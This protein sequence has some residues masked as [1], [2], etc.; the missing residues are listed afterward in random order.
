[1]QAS[2]SGANGLLSEVNGRIFF[3]TYVSEID[4]FPLLHLTLQKSNI[5][6]G[7]NHWGNSM[8]GL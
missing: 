6:A 4:M 5:H 1:M 8:K 2:I 3:S 7:N